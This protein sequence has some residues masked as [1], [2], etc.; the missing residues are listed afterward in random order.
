MHLPKGIA[1][2]W[3]RTLRIRQEL[4]AHVEAGE[5]VGF[6]FS[7]LRGFS[8]T[9]VQRGDHV[10]F[11]LAEAHVEIVREA[12]GD[13]GIVVKTLGDGVIAAFPDPSDAVLAAAAI[14]RTL[15]QRNAK[16]ADSPLYAG[17]GV[18]SG[19]PIMTDV[20]FI[21]HAVNVAQRLSAVAKG[22][23]ILTTESV[24]AYA[25]LPADL[26]YLPMGD[27]AL[28][29]VGTVR[30]VEVIWL[31]EV[32][33]VSDAGDLVTL[34]LTE[35]GT[36]VIERIKD[37]RIDARDALQTLLDLGG[38]G[39]GP[40]GWIER[41]AARLALRALREPRRPTVVAAEHALGDVRLARSPRGL[42]VTC[43]EGT[44]TLRDVDPEAADAFLA[45]ARRE[46]EAPL[47][48]L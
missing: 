43:A 22:G 1:M 34:I 40:A 19:T 13:R 15:R 36:L 10:A 28:K 42:R 7:D 16:D 4:R 29:G 14:Q 27:R 5:D 2:S 6:L 17:I 3:S 47:P 44:V 30:V 18:A 23:Q 41:A 9:A 45:A 12:I 38:P 26:R 8:R 35:R 33:R 20:D 11:E 21:G 37:P 25:A 39:G 32:A 46:A 31:R 24:Q 48:P